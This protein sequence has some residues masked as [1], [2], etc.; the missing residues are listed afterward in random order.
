ME[1]IN[2]QIPQKPKGTIIKNI[3]LYLV[4]FVALMMLIFSTANMIDIALRTFIFTKADFDYYYGPVA[5]Q[6]PE[7]TT[8]PGAKPVDCI[9]REEEKKRSEEQRSA[10]RQRDLVRDISMILVATPV[11]AYHWRLIRKKEESV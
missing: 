9:P 8:T 2:N 7:A 1:A 11:F 3:Y 6:P 4:S 10:Q 5:C